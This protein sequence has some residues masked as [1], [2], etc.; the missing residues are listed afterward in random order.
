MT[1]AGRPTG[2]KPFGKA[3]RAPATQVSAPAAPGIE[4][5]EKRRKR[6][7]HKGRLVY[8]NDATFS[9]QCMITD[10]SET[11]ARITVEPS[12]PMPEEVALVHLRDTLAFEAK[13]QWRRAEGTAGLKF[14]RAYDL[15]NAPTP[16]LKVLL[17]YCVE[18][19][20]R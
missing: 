1:Q 2:R 20:L 11:G 7:L 18:H 6:I 16:T 5:R 4:R 15:R 10:L 12:L 8:G 19:G 13:V 3:V 17:S 14:V 9:A